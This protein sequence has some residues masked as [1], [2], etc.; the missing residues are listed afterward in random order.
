MNADFDEVAGN[1]SIA[2]VGTNRQM[3]ETVGGMELMSGDADLL[4][5]YQLQTFSTT[6]VEKVLQ[7]LVRLEQY[8]ESDPAI[9]AMV[10]N[11]VE[12][13]ERFGVSE[14]QDQMLQG[15][16][17]VEVNVG[18]G[19]SNPMQRLNRVTTGLQTLGAFA[20]NLAAR[21][22]QEEVAKEIFGVMGFKDGSR[23]IVPEVPE[24]EQPEPPVDPQIQL[25]MIRADRQQ[26][27]KMMEFEFEMQLEQ[28]RTENQLRREQFEMEREMS[29]N[30]LKMSIEDRKFELE[31]KRLMSK[32]QESLQKHKV[33][34]AEQAIKQ[35]NE[36]ARF[37]REI[38]VKERQGTGI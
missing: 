30:A 22:D 5:E 36:N 14:I 17:T 12:M 27:L 29:G 21:I 2:S 24:E 11:K 26:Q 13:W 6:W 23:F 9:L 19:A 10:G 32:A 25:E 31:S 3:N 38:S 28:I 33:R 35:R 4:G 7:Q 8:Y 1:F 37:N 15:G 16:M 20:P 34:L 18:F